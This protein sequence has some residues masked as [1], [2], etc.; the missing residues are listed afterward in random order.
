MDMWKPFRLATSTRGFPSA[1]GGF[2]LPQLGHSTRRTSNSR[3]IR[4]SPQMAHPADLAVVP[5]HLDATRSA[6]MLFFFERRLSLI[7]RAFESPKIPR[8]S[9]IGSRPRAHAR[10]NIEEIQVL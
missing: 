4:V 7:T 1:T 6:H 2:T 10:E 3:Y 5:A 9:G 8:I